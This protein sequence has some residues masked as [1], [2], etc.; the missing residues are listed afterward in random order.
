MKADKL[1]NKIK[2][3]TQN[4]KFK[5]IKTLLKHYK[6]TLERQKGSHRIYKRENILVNIQNIKGEVK[7][8]QVKQVILA[9]EELLG[10]A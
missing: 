3:N 9:I 8:Y 2:N 10:G 4:V 1:F 5:E 7:P 6:F